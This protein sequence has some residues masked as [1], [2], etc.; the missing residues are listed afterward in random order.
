MAA[1]ESASRLV[2]LHELHKFKAGT[3]VRFICCAL[4]Y[5]ST[6][7]LLLVEHAYPA[8][9][10]QTPRAH[11]DINLV[12]DT[13]K[14]ELFEHGAWINVIGLVQAFRRQRPRSTLTAPATDK[15][16]TA[17]HPRVQAILVWDAGPLKLGDYEASVEKHR[18][19]FHGRGARYGNRGKRNRGQARVNPKKQ[20]RA[21]R[22][23]PN[24]RWEYE[25]LLQQQADAIER[26][27]TKPS[28]HRY[29]YI[30][31]QPGCGVS[32][33]DAREISR[34]YNWS[35]P[36]LHPGLEHVPSRTLQGVLYKDWLKDEDLYATKY[37]T[38]NEEFYEE[39]AKEVS[40]YERQKGGQ[41]VIA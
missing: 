34:H 36:P 9:A 13:T 15:E 39:L 25:Y 24:R 18:A 16:T 20:S 7:G 41:A 1:I 12:I 10:P 6:T 3:K 4:E 5:D 11:V 28:P 23:N 35:N 40:Q 14:S 32:A 30:C 17:N 37:A 8:T 38:S 29:R 31:P 33:N 27:K 2:F 26:E 22:E 21:D 19:A